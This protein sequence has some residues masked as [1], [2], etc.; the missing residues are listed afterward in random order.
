MSM[1]ISR[2]SFGAALGLGALSATLG[3]TSPVRAAT[4]RAKYLLL[5]FTN[6]TDTSLWSPVGS[7]SSQ[8]VH[9]PMTE[10][11]SALQSDLVIA[12]KLSSQGTCDN[13]GSPGGLTGIGYSGN[14][15]KSSID[16]FVARG[17][18]QQG[19][20]TPVA[21]VV[22]GGVT[23][24][25][26]TSFFS[27][28]Q[29]LTPIASPVAAFDALFGGSTPTPG[30]PD[31]ATLK[32]RREA[33]L[34]LAR[35]ELERLSGSLGSSQKP[36]L[37]LHADAL[38]QLE[39]RLQGGTSGG[40]ACSDLTAP[41]EAD[42][43]LL[44]SALH[45]DLAVHAFACG[46]TRVAAVQFGHHQS[47]QVDMPEVGPAG[48]WHN[49]FIH[50]DAYDGR[51]RLI[52]L[53]RWLCQRFVD[54]ALELQSLP[55]PDG[56]GSLYDHT[57]MVWARDMGDAVNHN[58]DDMRFVF[59]GGAGGYLRRSPNGVYIDGSGQSHQA[60][61][62]SVAHAMGIETFDG[63]GD[64]GGVRTPLSALQA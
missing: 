39:E 46:V 50:G 4:G 22:L 13:H 59:A 56:D 10:P 53:E 64:P 38:R 40:A 30:G 31:E 60:A 2:R 11:L 16:Q 5:F 43:A 9:G 20:Q 55:D 15:E 61:L 51:Q 28:N 44:S 17:L 47:T 19:L 7:S 14:H 63:F 35:A 6:G 33:S 24:E 42:Q 52:N 21:S 49:A 37:D 58:G 18:I 41:A 57:L 54:A 12:E 32:R 1:R 23:T 36:K 45:L 8:I 34:A 27:D 29:L 48:D 62:I 26:Q 3:H 25:Q